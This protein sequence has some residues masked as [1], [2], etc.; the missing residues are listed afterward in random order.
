[1]SL[2]SDVLC[3]NGCGFFGNPEWQWFCSKCW[4]E[5]QLGKQAIGGAVS[6]A[7]SYLQ[8]AE[9]PIRTT[10]AVSP[11]AKQ[12]TGSTT[13][14]TDHAT[15][16]ENSNAK[17]F[18]SFGHSSNVKTS[19]ASDDQSKQKSRS[20]RRS[21]IR[22]G[23]QSKA[24]PSTKT[25][26]KKKRF[27]Q[28]LKQMFQKG[29]VG[30]GS[31]DSPEKTRQK[32][33]SLKKSS[34]SSK[35]HPSPSRSWSSD[36]PPEAKVISSEFAS[37]L[38]SRLERPGITE[39][40]RYVKG[41]TERIIRITTELSYAHS[42]EQEQIDQLS[43]LVQ[44]F[45]QKLERR[46]ESKPQLYHALKEEDILKIMDYAEKY[47]MICCYRHLFCPT[48]TNDEDKDLELQNRIRNLN[49]VSTKDLNCSINESSQDVRD[50]LYEAI[51]D[52]LE[53][54]GRLAPQDKMDC[55]T[56]C[57]KKIFEMLKISNETPA[58]ADDFLPCLIY[59]CLKANPP[60]I[61]SNINFVTRFCNENKLRMGEA[62]YFFANLCCAMSFIENMT[63]ESISIDPK[64]FESYITGKS[65]PPGSWR[66]SL[67]MCDGL[68]VT[69]Q[70]LKSL[71]EL[72][73]KHDI[74]ISQA[75]Q[76]QQEMDAFQKDVEDEVK[77]V[78]DR[79][80][81]TLRHPKKPIRPDADVD[82]SDTS[83]LPP[84]LTP[85]NVQPENVSNLFP[86]STPQKDIQGVS[87]VDA[88]LDIPFPDSAC[89]L[90]ASKIATTGEETETQP[91]HL[92]ALLEDYEDF[93]SLSSVCTADD[94]SLL[95]VDISN[96]ATSINVS[97]YNVENTQVTTK[98]DTLADD[99]LVDCNQESREEKKCIASP[100]VSYVPAYRGLTAQIGNIPSI[101]CDNSLVL[102]DAEESSPFHNR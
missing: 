19:T 94:I 6:P 100:Q 25:E 81:Y 50:L 63:A 39:I 56:R 78:L 102:D 45:Y 13:M 52:I 74:V 14:H 16:R 86:M 35:P 68:Q 2:R 48:M 85:Q 98:D 46:L 31:K 62:G 17:S 9:D 92:S 24:L 36:F 42:V 7:K 1:M 23:S 28:N 40:S 93:M 64:E 57:S 33:E 18:L 12:H 66:T 38:N 3:R 95:S 76:L 8:T 87:D 73:K 75:L 65:V 49:W 88:T 91:G 72:K 70:N 83:A 15:S 41:I 53:I 90:M 26:D 99:K 82:E 11:A 89:A 84:P 21:P 20:P 22:M 101:S 59:I 55:L 32:A 77:A 30:F 29:R 51:N 44:E 80:K 27:D 67:L 43:A 10:A 5:H 97:D 58:S 4:R 54:D 34:S 96:P 60:R 47:V 79:T 69:S 71:A 61:Q 37:F